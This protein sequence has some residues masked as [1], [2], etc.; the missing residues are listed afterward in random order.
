MTKFYELF[1]SSL[2]P[3][4]QNRRLKFFEHMEISPTRQDVLQWNFCGQRR[5]FRGKE[6]A[7]LTKQI[8]TSRFTRQPNELFSKESAAS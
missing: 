3:A 6:C 7:V 1:S 8:V 5:W 4:K 2:Y